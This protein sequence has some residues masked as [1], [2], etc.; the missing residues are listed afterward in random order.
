VPKKV[1]KTNFL[2]RLLIVRLVPFKVGSTESSSVAMMM[3]ILGSV[4]GLEWNKLSQ[5]FG[6][7]GVVPGLQ[8]CYCPGTDRF[9]NMV[10]VGNFIEV[11]FLCQLP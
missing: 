9:L 1:G 6:V 4:C 11:K 3:M 5:R 7:T 2:T 8:N 10:H